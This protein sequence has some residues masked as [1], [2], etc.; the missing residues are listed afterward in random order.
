MFHRHCTDALLTGIT[1]LPFSF[2]PSH[3]YDQKPGILIH[4][5]WKKE[6]SS[7]TSFSHPKQLIEN[8]DVFFN[9]SSDIIGGQ[10]S[11]TVM[12]SCY[13]NLCCC[14]TEFFHRVIF[15]PNLTSKSVTLRISSNLDDYQ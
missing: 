6:D 9:L 15:S 14:Q 2:Q 1:P 3:L 11:T 5:Q 7:T 4:A 13:I 10:R 8:V 12:F